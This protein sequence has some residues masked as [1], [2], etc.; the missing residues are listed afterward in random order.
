MRAGS[1]EEIGSFL[2]GVFEVFSAQYV[3]KLGVISV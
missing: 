3:L 1:L 2:L